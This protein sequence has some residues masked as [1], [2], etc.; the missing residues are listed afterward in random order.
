MLVPPRVLIVVACET[1]DVL[2]VLDRNAPAR[3][4]YER[5]GFSP[6]GTAQDFD[7][8]VTPVPEIRM[9]RLLG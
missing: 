8:L 3:N 6:D 1:V 7:A 9:R 2:W 4:F 5:H